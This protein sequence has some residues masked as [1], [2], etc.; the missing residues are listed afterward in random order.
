MGKKMKCVAV[1]AAGGVLLGCIPCGC[2][3]C[4]PCAWLPGVVSSVAVEFLLDNDAVFDLFQD[5]FGTGALY[6]DRFV[7]EPTRAEPDDDA[8]AA[9][10]AAAGR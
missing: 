2:N 5:D 10:D 1:I 4:N 6:D 7:A 8:Q 3:F 9:A